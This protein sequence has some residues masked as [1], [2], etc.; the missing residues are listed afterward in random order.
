MMSMAGKL[1]PLLWFLAFLSPLAAIFFAIRFYAVHRRRR[2]ER[3]RHMPAAAFTIILLVCAVI[4]FPFGMIFGASAACS[5]PGWGNLCGLFGV[6]V[7]GPLASSLAIVIVASLIAAL[8]ADEPELTP[9]GDTPPPRTSDPP[10]TMETGWY[11]RLWRGKYPLSRSFWGFFALGTLVGWIIAMNP[12]FLFLPG[13]AIAFRLVFLG[14]QIAAGV[15]VWRSA[16]ALV[17][18]RAGTS[19]MTHAVSI[20]A[21]TARS[22]VILLVGFHVLVLLRGVNFFLSHSHL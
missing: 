13:A 8:P 9:A 20:K 15:G 12:A 7:T 5:S 11:Q 18:A 14:Y 21:V 1:F 3:G 10:A 6:F 2:P 22:V 17:A 16:D 4:A 19:S